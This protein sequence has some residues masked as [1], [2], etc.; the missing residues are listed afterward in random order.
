MVCR[1]FQPTP[2]RQFALLALALCAA[3]PCVRA[4]KPT[5]Y[6]IKAVFLFNFARF[7]DWPEAGTTDRPLVIG[8]LGQD[9]F[10]VRLDDALRGEKSNNR[11]LAVRRLK[12]VD[13]AL[14][15]DV[16]FISR[17]E[18][19]KLAQILAKV[20][21]RPILTVSDIPSFAELGGMVGLVTEDEK[22]RLHINVE[23]AKGANLA[24]SA[25]LL[26]PAQIVTTRKTSL[27]PFR[28]GLGFSALVLLLPSET[29]ACRRRPPREADDSV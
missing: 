14:D 19:A 11:S 20:K 10:G 24:I 6:D 13:D 4:Q 12:T 18:Q 7:V 26:R 21:E 25:K 2:L 9:P 5:E 23:A 3:A 15:C 8:V 29:A 22:V 27:S 28:S 16:L 1:A 17:S